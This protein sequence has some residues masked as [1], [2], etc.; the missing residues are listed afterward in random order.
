MDSQL[1]AAQQLLWAR[2]YR[3]AAEIYR[4]LLPNREARKGLATAEYWAGDFRAALRDFA[5]V[6]DAESRKAVAD[7]KAAS[8]PWAVADA[9]YASDDQPLRRAVASAAYTFFS[10]PLTKWTATAGTYLFDPHASAP[11]ASVAGETVFPWQHLRASA[12]L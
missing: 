3:E 6:N 4:R 9:A 10:D 7:I 8:A 1:R 2:R 5:L 12:S 11:F